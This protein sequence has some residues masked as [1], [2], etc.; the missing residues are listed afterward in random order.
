[1]TRQTSFFADCGRA[2]DTVS[3][4]YQIR[5]RNLENRL[6]TAFGYRYQI[7]V[8]SVSYHSIGLPPFAARWPIDVASAGRASGRAPATGERADKRWTPKTTAA[9]C[10]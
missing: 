8:R 3:T 9:V 6:R 2:F 7:G 4:R 5:V 1:M 10:A